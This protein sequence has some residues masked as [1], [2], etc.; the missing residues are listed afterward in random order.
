VRTVFAVT[1]PLVRK[2]TP[3]L[4]PMLVLVLV[5]L[6]RKLSDV[7][8]QQQGGDGAVRLVYGADSIVCT[9]PVHSSRVVMLRLS[10]FI[11]S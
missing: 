3:M 11:A 8:A 7:C 6:V 1:V 5:L 10:L 4:A 9:V 2:L